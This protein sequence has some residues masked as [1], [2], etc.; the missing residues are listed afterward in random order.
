MATAR[1]DSFV[2]RLADDLGVRYQQVAD[3]FARAADE[4]D[5]ADFEEV[6][7]LTTVMEWLRGNED[8]P[9]PPVFEEP[10]PEEP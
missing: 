9:Q 5:A 10:P 1:F 7:E 3:A 4:I 6:A 2:A 8:L